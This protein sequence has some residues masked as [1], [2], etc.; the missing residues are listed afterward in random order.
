MDNARRFPLVGYRLAGMTLL[1]CLLLALPLASRAEAGRPLY[2]ALGEN[3]KWG[4]I[5]SAGEWAIAPQFDAADDF[6]GEYA[7]AYVRPETEDE[8][9]PASPL[10]GII[11]TT[12]A[13]VLPPAYDVFYL[14]DSGGAAGGW[15]SGYY[16]L[17][18]WKKSARIQGW[19]NIPNGYFSGLRYERVYADWGAAA[20]GSALQV[21]ESGGAWALVDR[22]TGEYLI[23]PQE[24]YL[25]YGVYGEGCIPVEPFALLFSDGHA[26]PLPEGYAFASWTSDQMACG[27][28]PVE[29]E[30]TGLVGFMDA[31]GRIALAPRFLGASAFD[32]NGVAC[33]QFPEGDYG[34]ID[35]KGSVLYRGAPS[36]Y[37]F[38]Q[39]LAVVFDESG[40]ESAVA[41]LRP[42]GETAF[43]LEMENLTGLWFWDDNG[44]GVYQ[45]AQETWHYMEEWDWKYRTLYAYGLVSEQGDVLTG[46]VFYLTEDGFGRPLFQ[47]GLA[48]LSELESLRV[49]FVDAQGQ[50]A[51]PPAY[52]AARPFRSGL[53]PVWQGRTVRFINPAGEILFSYDQQ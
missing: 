43:R 4:Y 10:G 19:F 16:Q 5:D 47:E 25:P 22:F 13:W 36:F 38:S 23:P 50:W 7:A 49:G 40:E 39:G 32:E 6:R 21:T 48:A 51:I 37:S 20:A 30:A 33:V 17:S 11:D 42:D 35:A 1:L 28:I 26:V 3:G 27:L 14:N 44:V 53:A 9:E 15:D 29:E 31:E 24:D 45:V 52:D 34:H 41:V 46:P 2:A 8:E 12:G 18:Q